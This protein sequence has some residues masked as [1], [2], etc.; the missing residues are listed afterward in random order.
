VRAQFLEYSIVEVTDAD[1]PFAR[2]QEEQPE[3]LGHCLVY[4]RVSCA[5]AAEKRSSDGRAPV[6]LSRAGS[7]CTTCS[8]L[9]TR[10]PS[11]TTRATK[12][13]APRPCT[14]GCEACVRAC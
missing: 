10:C 3:L 2:L 11:L 5:A 13:S 14:R 9:M 6:H 4:L 1:N 8:T 7:R 12:R